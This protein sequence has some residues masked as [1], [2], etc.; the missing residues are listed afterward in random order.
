[1]LDANGQSFEIA[2]HA[3]LA[4]QAR[5]PT[6]ADVIQE[7]IDLLVRPSSGTTRTY[8]VMLDLHARNVI[9]HIPVDKLDYSRVMH[10]VKSMRTKGRSPKT[11]H[12]VHGLISAAMNTAGM[13]GYI[14]ATLLVHP[15]NPCRGVQ[16]PPIEKA[17][18][19]AMFLTH[20]EF[21]LIM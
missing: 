13:L 17:E 1:L 15:R 4:N 18:D 20:A 2:Q 3:I 16:L 21:S 9:G 6:V 10:W 19:E 12:N 7:H 5:V 14:P 11:I 8:Q